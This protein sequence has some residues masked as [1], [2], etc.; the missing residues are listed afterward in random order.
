MNSRQG[1][2][3]PSRHHLEVAQEVVTHTLGRARTQLAAPHDKSE[4]V[5]VGDC[6]ADEDL[7]LPE[8]WIRTQ[9]LDVWHEL[10]HLRKVCLPAPLASCRWNE[11]TAEQPAQ[12]H[13]MSAACV[14][15][16]QRA[17]LQE[18]AVLVDE[19]DEL[20]QR[21]DSADSVFHEQHQRF[22]E[23]LVLLS[24]TLSIPDPILLR[25]SEPDVHEFE[26]GLDQVCVWAK[27]FH[28]YRVLLYEVVCE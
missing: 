27:Q 26:L 8:Q 11:D 4:P 9:K 2:H 23:V 12:A 6:V 20:L 28:R 25:L 17:L 19:R 16:K 21:V 3:D 5:L 10:Q 18:V 24:K 13:A 7:S 15:D 14:L 1:G 22:S